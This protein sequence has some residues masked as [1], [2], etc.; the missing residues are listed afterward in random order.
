MLII[1][2]MFILLFFLILQNKET[3]IPYAIIKTTGE[4]V[5]LSTPGK[6]KADNEELFNKL[7]FF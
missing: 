7:L 6:M 3:F 4:K 5:P 2:I 1:I